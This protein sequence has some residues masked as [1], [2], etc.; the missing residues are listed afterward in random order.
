[1]KTPTPREYVYIARESKE[2]METSI[3]QALALGPV[4][5]FGSNRKVDATLKSLKKQGKIAFT[6]KNQGGNGWELV[7]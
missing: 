2:Q 6:F 3:L 5:T 4:Q 1:M 7:K